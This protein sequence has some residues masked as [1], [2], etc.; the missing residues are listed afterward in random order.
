MTDSFKPVRKQSLADAVFAQLRSRILTG[1][2]DPGAPL[3]AERVLAQKLQVNRGAVREALKRLEQARLI[4][5]RHGGHT[6]VLDFRQT[7]GTGLLSALLIDDEGNLNARVARSVLEMRSA[8]APSIARLCARRGQQVVQELDELLAQM[9]QARDDLRALQLASLEF[10][11]ILVKGSQNIAYQ[12]A[13]NSLRESYAHFSHLLTGAMAREF[14]AYDDYLAMRDAIAG[15]REEEA[16]Q[17]AAQIMDL[18][19][20]ALGPILN[21]LAGETKDR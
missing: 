18:G 17:I 1:E 16:A 14:Q 10:W 7:A 3:P 15:G 21:T 19:E 6:Q 2:I 8:L 12:L 20:S 13:I 9:D 4:S 5:I 11:K